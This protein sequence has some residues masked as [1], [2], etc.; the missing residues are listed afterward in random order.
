MCHVQEES[1]TSTDHTATSAG[2]LAPETPV[3]AEEA[4]EAEGVPH[5]RSSVSFVLHLQQPGLEPWAVLCSGEG[6]GR[7]EGV[8]SFSLQ[9]LDFLGHR[10]QTQGPWVK[11]G[12]P[13]YFIWPG[14]LFP[15][16]GSAKLLAPS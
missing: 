12:P 15:P 7:V 1:E 5:A 3:P 2:A 13:P 4:H 8:W 9:S 16:S 6:R 14:T 11:S 10:W